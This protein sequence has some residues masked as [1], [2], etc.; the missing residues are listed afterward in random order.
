MTWSSR[1]NRPFWLS[2]TLI[3]ALSIGACSFGGGRSA[4]EAPPPE[5]V[6]PAL[7]NP[8]PAVTEEQALAAAAKRNAPAVADVPSIAPPKPTAEPPLPTVPPV[9]VPQVSATAKPLP[10]VTP[11]VV[12]PPAVTRP[13]VAAPAVPTPAKPA[14]APVTNG[15]PTDP[16]AKVRCQ[17]GGKVQ[18]VS[19]GYCYQVGKIIR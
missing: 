12:T 5:P 2:L 9:P 8:G 16:T 19:A 4:S 10:T 6:N 11:P 14:P 17:L 15:P 13:E 18:T 1:M 3:G 7:V